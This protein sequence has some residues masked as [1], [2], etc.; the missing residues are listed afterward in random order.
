[1]ATLFDSQHAYGAPAQPSYG[2]GAPQPELQF[3]AG[4]TSSG[5]TGSSY[6]ANRPSLEGNVGG[7]VG[8]GPSG[9]GGAIQG[10]FWSA[11]TP[12]GYPDEPPLLEGVRTISRAGS[13]P[14]Q[15]SASTSITSRRS[16]V[17]D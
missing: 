12:A 8:A 17:R 7:G 15:S 9:F 16:R 4:D 13:E 11:F 3:F 6:Y 5:A 14:T 2:Y 1:M 10:G